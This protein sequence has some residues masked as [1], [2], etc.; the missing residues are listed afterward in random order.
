MSNDDTSG[1][2]PFLNPTTPLAFMSKKD[3]D[4]LTL[5][6][7]FA[8]GNLSVRRLF[9]DFVRSLR[10]LVPDFVLGR[11]GFNGPGLRVILCTETKLDV[12]HICHL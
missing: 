7:H 6:R 5:S 4:L 2:A 9:R 10:I 12:N 1:L 3:G 8:F 11:Y